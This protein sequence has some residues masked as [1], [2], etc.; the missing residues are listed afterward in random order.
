VTAPPSEPGSRGMPRGG[1]RAALALGLAVAAAG[2]YAPVLD[3][4]FSAFDDR[5]FL[6]ENPA[7]DAGLSGEGLAW[8]AGAT[9]DGNRIPLTWISF[10]I[11]QELHGLSP[12]GT[13]ATN[14]VLHALASALLL[15][16]LARL[17][18]GLDA[19][20]FVA[21]VFAL[22][23]LHVESVAWAIERKDVLSGALFAATL[24]A[25]AGYAARP[26]ALRY[27]AVCVLLALGLAAKPMLVTVP[28]VL[29]LLDAWPLG[30]LGSAA[31]VRRAVIEKLP[32]LA[33]S[34]VASL[35]ALQV[36]TAVGAREAVDV[37]LPWRLANALVA[38]V[39]YLRKA[40]APVDLAV[41]Y[42]HP[43][44]AL[45]LAAVGVAAVVVA[46]VS[47]LA[48]AQWRRR[49]W[50]AVGWLW[51][52]GMLVPVLGIVQVGAQAMADRYTYLPLVGATLP[53]ACAGAELARRSAAARAGAVGAACL[54][55]VAC[56]VLARGQIDHWRDDVALWRH[57][58][59]VTERNAHAHNALGAALLA[60][61]R[62]AEARAELERALA[63]RPELTDAH[64]NLGVALL[65]AGEPEAAVRSLS[66]GLTLPA[67]RRAEVHGRLGLAQLDAGRPGAA[68]VQAREGLR[69]RDDLG[70][71]HAVLGFAQVRL[72]RPGEALDALRRAE[73]LG[74]AE[75]GL[76]A[77]MARAFQETGR[78]V[79][80]A[81]RWRQALAA[82]PDDVGLANN[83]AWL[84]ATGDPAV[85]DPAEAV[86]WAE[87][88]ARAAPAHA[89]VLDTLAVSYHAA[90]R[91]EAALD[92]SARAARAARAAGDPA[93]ADA[94][95]AR[96]ERWSG[97][98]VR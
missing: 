80:A 70:L 25:W 69:L 95:E 13:H 67:A 20:A 2:L 96:A 32:L 9:V 35:F 3:H 43:R 17:G 78:P 11:D 10:L 53:V 63:I 4:G 14:V 84:L 46:A 1:M 7:L 93:T 12:R 52:L 59:A 27:G 21:A 54:A 33:L 83:L 39:A 45:P 8:A 76:H 22:H 81:A 28:F 65:R 74:F 88:A 97:G 91:R 89:A 71:L 34:A 90:G 92:A 40:V 77:A 36:Q 38:A 75:P 58:L 94:I 41:F 23:P 37:A 51:Y 19:S 42:P 6:V 50:I 48:A 49:P 87:R 60:R 29:L 61:G 64:V 98:D 15:L 85:R 55:L 31:A 18:A 57:A 24:L 79:E 56:A 26:G 66:R 82:R 72:G 16:A 73:A 47:L 5:T 62:D 44:D 86:R 30:R 68:R